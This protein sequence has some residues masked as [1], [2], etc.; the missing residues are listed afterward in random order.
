MV[1]HR[2]HAVVAST[3][4]PPTLRTRLQRAATSPAAK[5]TYIAIGV[6]GLAALGVAIFGTRRFKQ[7]VVR[8]MRDAVSDQAERLWS[9]ARPLRD[10]LS[11]L[12]SRA[13]SQSGREKLIQSF[14]S[15]IG[16][17]RAV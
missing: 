11:G 14:Q 12:I 4:R 13:A 1:V 10:Q 9:E 6:V 15:W 17:F 2:S 3:R 7:E 16:H 8:P 5:I